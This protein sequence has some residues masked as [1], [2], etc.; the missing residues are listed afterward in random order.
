MKILQI[1]VNYGSSSTGKLVQILHESCQK[2]GFSGEVYFGRGDFSEQQ[3]VYKISNQSEVYM[4][5]ALTRLTGYTDYFSPR[6]T[7]RVIK[8]IDRFRPDIVHLHDLHGYY[9]NIFPLI[10][11]LQKLAIPIVW[12]FHCEFMYTGKCGHALD[13]DKWKSECFK[14]PQIKTYPRSL[15]FDRTREMYK[16]KKR[17]LA[18]S[19][20]LTIVTPSNW[21][22]DRVKDSF[23][24]SQPIDVIYNGTDIDVFKLLKKNDLR[25]SLNINDKFVILVVGSNIFS[26]SKGGNWVVDLAR[27]QNHSNSIFLVVGSDSA[28]SIDLPRNV[29][30]IGRI[31]DTAELSK[32]YN[33]ADIFLLTS[34]KETFS[35]VCVES[36]ASG[37][38]IVGFEAG[39]PSEIIPNGYGSFVP[40]GDIEKLNNLI[41]DVINCRVR[42]N[43]EEV[44]REFAVKNY[45][46]SSMASKYFSLYKSILQD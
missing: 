45:S 22:A 35:M 18:E 24:K 17:L 29:I 16:R 28:T 26:D 6:A 42:F 36:L 8:H 31:N 3:H 12:T 4:H 10:R 30:N 9:I 46:Q 44:C 23:L 1:D 39:A 27:R 19:T 43:S 33:A 32:Y 37:T 21:L 34:E 38:P 20:N 7:N 11:Y 13:C 5:A 2:F 41:T 25:Q 15:F 14:C 40:Y